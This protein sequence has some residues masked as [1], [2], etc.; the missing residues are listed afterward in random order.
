M[1]DPR[2]W[3]EEGGEGTALERDL[4]GAGRDAGPSCEQKRTMW[5]AIASRAIPPATG[6][7]APPASGAAAS[8][9][10]TVSKGAA[11]LVLLGAGIVAS[12]R[13]M[14][15]PIPPRA[16]SSAPATAL[17]APPPPAPGEQPPG[18]SPP[19]VGAPAAEGPRPVKVA[20]HS[21]PRPNAV[22]AL[23]ENARASQLREESAM[24]LGARRVL[25]AGDPARA[26]TLLDAARTRF[27]DGSL[28]Q[29]REALTIEA[30]VRSGQRA[31][32]TKRAEAFLRDYPKSPHGADV[33]SLVL[34]P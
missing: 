20:A 27:P 26:L 18:A 14:L 12:Y 15:G 19:P 29:E 11:I 5:G 6:P 33:R 7:G 3:T 2:R 16:R 4:I 17:E 1:N 9:G 24:I 10:L 23:A 30:L 21:A 34:E 32:A 25:R 28:V 31:L 8:T 22:A 13:T